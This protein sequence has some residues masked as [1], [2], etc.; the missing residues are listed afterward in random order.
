VLGVVV[1]CA[2]QFFIGVDGLAVAIALPSLQRDLGVAPIDAQWVLTAY[3]L[4]FGG[5]MLLGG[6]LGDL[7]GR[8][9][10]L[11]WGMGLFAGGSVLAGLAPGLGWLVAA[12]ALQGLGAAAA[13]PAALALIGSLFGPGEA[14]TRALSLLAAMASVG[15]MSGLLLGGVVTGLL[16]WRW[17]FLLLAPAAA[18]VCV[19]AP[20]LLPE[21]RAEQRAARPD[22]AGAVLVTAAGVGVLFGVTRIE[23]HGLAAA[24]T[25]VPLLAGLALLAAFVAWE[26]RAAAPLVRFEVLRTHSLRA[27]SLG[28]GLNAVAF[29]AIVYVGT[30]YLQFAL[31]YGPL[32]AGVALL[33]LDAVAFVVPLVAAGAI[34]RRSPR[35]LLLGSFTF[36]ALALLWLSAAGAQA[37]YAPDV[38]GPLVILGASL[39]VAF[40]VLTQEAVADVAPGDKGLAAGIFETSNHLFGGGVGVAVYAT[41]LSAAASSTTDADGYRAAFLAGTVLAAL[42]IAVAL[43][44]RA[45]RRS[46]RTPGTAARAGSTG[47][48]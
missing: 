39:S 35:A 27:A 24:V 22:V 14:R 28:V 7:Y 29:T 8:R 42:G 3:A 16:G 23:H 48:P 38:L 1:A 36:T 10:M 5:T 31:G 18:A 6:R 15:V 11:T 20:R 4:A 19:V 46:P 17:V 44:S 13:V 43:S 45:R 26:R 40:V 47:S 32:Q 21:A 9:R 25:V 12:R 41:V 33:P 30:L 37:R 2:A 34:E